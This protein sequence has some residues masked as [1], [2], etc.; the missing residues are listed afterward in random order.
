MHLW[1]SSCTRTV[2]NRPAGNLDACTQAQDSEAEVEHTLDNL[3]THYRTSPTCL[4]ERAKVAYGRG[5]VRHATALW[6]LAAHAVIAGDFGGE[7]ALS[8]IL[9]VRCDGR[10]AV[11]IAL[12]CNG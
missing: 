12:A 11:R 1:S 2:H 7:D 9:R 5:N 6:R 8:V 3:P 4:A 10:P